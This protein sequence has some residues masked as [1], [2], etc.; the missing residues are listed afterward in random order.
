MWMF[1]TKAL[2]FSWCYLSH[3]LFIFDRSHFCKKNGMAVI[4]NFKF[5][6]KRI[7]K[8]ILAFRSRGITIFMS[9]F[10]FS[11]SV[12]ANVPLKMAPNGFNYTKQ[13]SPAVARKDALQPI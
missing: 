5:M 12:T 4:L 3:D 7:I 2:I 10:T 8:N 1:W 9:K 11:G 6:Q 13:E